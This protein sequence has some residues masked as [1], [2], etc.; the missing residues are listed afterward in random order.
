MRAGPF[1][2]VVVALFVSV[3]GRAA[4]LAVDVRDNDGKPATNAVV[5][6]YPDTPIATGT[7]TEK[8][9]I[10]QR[11]ETFL[12]L[13]VVVRKGGHVVFTNNDTTMHQVYSFSPIKQFQ[14]VIPQGQVSQPVEFP[15]TGIAAIGCNI[16]DQMIAYVFVADAPYAAVVDGSGHVSLDVHEGHYRV[17][18]WHPQMGLAAQPVQAQATVTAAGAHAEVGL[19]L[20]IQSARSMKHMH[21][22]Y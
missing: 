15:Q 1:V 18:V 2:L 8:A 4:T 19:P 11:H 9:V 14:F 17:A 6:L 5:S 7:A 10:D 21:M 16:H 13:V 20:A 12:P 22:D 3:S